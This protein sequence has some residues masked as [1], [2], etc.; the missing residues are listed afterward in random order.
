MQQ[1]PN[2]IIPTAIEIVFI[3]LAGTLGY[4]SNPQSCNSKLTFEA[5]RRKIVTRIGERWPSWRS[6]LVSVPGKGV[7]RLQLRR[8]EESNRVF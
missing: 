5:C 1:A 7:F 4:E 8:R 3:Q 6:R 2:A